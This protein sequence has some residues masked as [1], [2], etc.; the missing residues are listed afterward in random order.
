MGARAGPSIKRWVL[1]QPASNSKTD[2]RV[3]AILAMAKDSGAGGTCRQRRW[4]HGFG[5]DAPALAV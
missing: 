5:H 1:A 3:K 2:R 4:S